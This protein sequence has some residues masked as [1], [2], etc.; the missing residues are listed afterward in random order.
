MADPNISDWLKDAV[1]ARP[2]KRTAGLFTIIVRAVASS[3]SPVFNFISSEGR[4]KFLSVFAGWVQNDQNPLW[5]RKYVF[6]RRKVKTRFPCKHFQ[7]QLSSDDLQE[8]DH[9]RESINRAGRNRRRMQ[10]ISSHSS[11]TETCHEKSQ[12]ERTFRKKCI[13]FACAGFDL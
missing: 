12:G 9:K 6:R 4:C 10:Q 7:S 13:V 5:L 1:Q 3:S 8:Q 2:G 11:Q